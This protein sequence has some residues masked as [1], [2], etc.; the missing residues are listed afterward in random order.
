MSVYLCTQTATPAD[1]DAIEAGSILLW[2]HR[3][4]N[5]ED[6]SKNKGK[7]ASSVGTMIRWALFS[8]GSVPTTGK[9][10]LCSPTHPDRL[11]KLQCAAVRMSGPVPPHPVRP[12]ATTD[13]LTVRSH[14]AALTCTCP[15]AQ[16]SAMQR[17]AWPALGCNATV[18][19]ARWY[20]SV[21]TDRCANLK[22]LWL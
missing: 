11:L 10:L 12:I 3:C 20:V 4:Q 2:N 13:T 19:A 18:S 14:F 7:R 1:F 17:Q 8:P 5:T 21:D 15:C 16:Y 22:Q 9:A 6:Q